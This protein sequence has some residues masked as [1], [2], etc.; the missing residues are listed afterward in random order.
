M[1]FYGNISK[2]HECYQCINSCFTLFYSKITLQELWMFP[3]L[4]EEYQIWQKEVPTCNLANHNRGGVQERF[5]SILT[6]QS[7]HLTKVHCVR[8][9]VRAVGNKELVFL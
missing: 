1:I 3:R 7:Q 9:Q 2:H 5:K 8:Y 6:G 4:L